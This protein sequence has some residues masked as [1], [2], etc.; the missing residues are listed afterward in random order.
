M[1]KIGVFD[2]GIGGL[3][4]AKAIRNSLPNVPICYFGDTAHLP[5]GDKSSELILKYSQRIIRFLF[6]QD[7]DVIV[8]ACNSASSVLAKHNISE[9]KSVPIVNVVDPVVDFLEKESSIKSLGIIGT[10]ATINSQIYPE[11]IAN[12]RKDIKVNTLATPL[13]APMIE[14]GFITHNISELIIKSYLSYPDFYN[15]DALLLACTHYPLIK[16]EVQIIKP[17]VLVLDNANLTAEHIKKHYSF[18]DVP[19]DSKCISEFFVSDLT[20]SFEESAKHFFGES[21]V[22]KEQDL[23]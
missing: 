21:V 22:L 17:N 11:K 16:G 3:T 20:Q 4:V 10:K 7:C 8:V 14:E 9:Y 1:K 18:D 19:L 12:S 13:L 23:N 5:Y 15:I 6:Q 2:S